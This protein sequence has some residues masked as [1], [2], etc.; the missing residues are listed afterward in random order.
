MLRREK[1]VIKAKLRFGKK[2]LIVLCPLSPL[3]E[4]AY[5]RFLSSQEVLFLKATVQG[6]EPAVTLHHLP[7]WRLQHRSDGIL[8]GDHQLPPQSR[9]AVDLSEGEEEEE[10]AESEDSEGGL[11]ESEGMK[12][13]STDVHSSS[14]EDEDLA[15][16]GQGMVGEEGS[17]KGKRER[18]KRTF[19]ECRGCPF[20][21]YL[22]CITILRKIA[23]HLEMIRVDKR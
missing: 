5:L 21:L 12:V 3:Q 8:P 17:V 4:E 16:C 11:A 9:P 15:G 6:D 18:R 22:P 20:C 10:E 2:D 19:M 13:V 1:S 23:N 7:L 14:E